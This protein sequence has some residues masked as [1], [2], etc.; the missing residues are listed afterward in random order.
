MGIKVYLF[1]CN[2]QGVTS[3][4]LELKH[5]MQDL[6]LYPGLFSLSFSSEKE[7]IEKINGK[8]FLCSRTSGVALPFFPNTSPRPCLGGRLG[9]KVARTRLRVILLRLRMNSQKKK[10]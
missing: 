2:S 5:V 10:L 9:T 6:I 4:F 1:L 7:A 8:K 3:E